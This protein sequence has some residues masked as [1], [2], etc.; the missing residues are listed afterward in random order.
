MATHKTAH[1]AKRDRI[2]PLQQQIDECTA[3]DTNKHI[4]LQKFPAAFSAQVSRKTGQLDAG[5]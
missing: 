1:F 2:Q 4:L 5:F 3:I